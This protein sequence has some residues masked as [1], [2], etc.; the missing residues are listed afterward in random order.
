MSFWNKMQKPAVGCWIWPGTTDVKGYGR[1][2]IEKTPS[3]ATKIVYA[4]RMAYELF[5]GVLPKGIESCHRCDNPPCIRP[6]HLFAGTHADNMADGRSKNR[7]NPC[8]ANQPRGEDSVK[9]KLTS[10]QA[11]TIRECYALGDITMDAL[12]NRYGVYPATIH[13]IIRGKRWIEA[14]GDATSVRICR[15]IPRETAELIRERY[16]NGERPTDLARAYNITATRVVQ[17]GKHGY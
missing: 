13:A 11:R 1:L 17:L 14:G 7:F 8:G 2:F 3:G 5:C 15:K 4:H 16:Q 9:S 6:D 10:E 12:A